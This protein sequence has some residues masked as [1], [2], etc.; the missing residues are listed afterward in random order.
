MSVKKTKSA[1]KNEN[2]LPDLRV[3]ILAGG[4][5]TRFWP[6]S[7]K[8]RPKQYLKIISDKSLIEETIRRVQGLVPNSRIYTVAV[9]QQTRMIRKLLPRLPQKN[10]LVEPEARN[11]APSL[12]LATA[13]IY[14]KNPEAVVAALPADH[15][16]KNV[17]V[18]KQK[19]IRAAK[20]AYQHKRIVMFGIPPTSPA[21]GYGYIHCPEDN[22]YTV[23][24]EKFYEVKGFRE[25]P[26][27]PTAL[28]F[29]QSGDYFW[30]SGIFLWRADVFEE[31]L[32][33][34]APE[35]FSAWIKILHA[36]R[37]NDRRK[38]SRV[39]REVPALS[40]DYALIEKVVGPIMSRG[41]FGWSDLG[42]WSSLYE[43]L[44]QDEHCNVSQGET[45]S[46]D[47]RNC[48]V[49]NS[50]R[51][52]ALIGVDDLIVVNSGDALLVCRRDQDQRVKEIVEKLRKDHPEYT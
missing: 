14:L 3:V 12:L 28:E 41:D 16:I 5:G 33:E 42:S 22:A 49:F 13:C 24:G 32:R 11:T 39:F 9:N 37:K 17:E 27:L 20:A 38:L 15:Y 35:L 8:K 2:Q 25:K 36:L 10:L 43:F 46:L 45:V 7:R 30:N 51:L 44:T 19:L 1:K 26:D 18:F 47:S 21:T 40:I 34:Y 52:T 6:L 48:L 23:D 50:G 29:L 4:S 31:N